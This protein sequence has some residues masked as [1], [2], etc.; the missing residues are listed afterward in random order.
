VIVLLSSLL[1]RRAAR[2]KEKRCQEPFSRDTFFSS[3]S[4]SKKVPDTFFPFFPPGD[5]AVLT[6]HAAGGT[7]HRMVAAAAA[8]AG[9]IVPGFMLMLDRVFG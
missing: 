9:D 3:R 8:P 4:H 2:G 1:V 7:V 5:R 6:A